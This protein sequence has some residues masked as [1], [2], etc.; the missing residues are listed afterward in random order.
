MHVE[1]VGTELTALPEIIVQARTARD[2][3]DRFIA[4]LE[5]VRLDQAGAME[6]PVR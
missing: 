6:E 5:R 4:L 1:E 3:L 2:S